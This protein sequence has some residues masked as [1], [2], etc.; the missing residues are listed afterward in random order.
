MAILHDISWIIGIFVFIFLWY[1]ASPSSYCYQV[2]DSSVD[3]LLLRRI[4]IRR[5]L[6]GDVEEVRI[7]SWKE[8]LPLPFFQPV[9]TYF[10]MGFAESWGNRLWGSKVFL[11]RKRGI[12]RKFILSPKDPQAFIQLV[13]EKRRGLVDGRKQG[14]LS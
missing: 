13:E 2:T 3:I 12:S 1:L 10:S 14:T 5:I 8:T 9:S 4:P 11:R 6:I 7:L